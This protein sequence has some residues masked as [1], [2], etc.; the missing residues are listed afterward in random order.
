MY[1][2]ASAVHLHSK[3]ELHWRHF[4]DNLGLNQPLKIH[5]PD[6]RLLKILMLRFPGFFLLSRILQFLDTSHS[7]SLLNSNEI[8]GY[9]KGGNENSLLWTYLEYLLRKIRDHHP[10]L[11]SGWN[12]KPWSH[13]SS[14]IS[15]KGQK[16]TEE[17]SKR[18]DG[19]FSSFLLI[20]SNYAENSSNSL[21]PYLIFLL[22]QGEMRFFSQQ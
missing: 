21:Q 20:N 10:P 22:V 16:F 13:H 5:P 11:L 9:F 8:L 1:V 18:K 7:W 19:K 17:R 14:K 3:K 2:N 15:V 6:F 12:P 4:F